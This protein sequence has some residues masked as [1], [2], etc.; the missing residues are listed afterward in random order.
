MMTLLKNILKFILWVLAF[1]VVY[2]LISLVLTS[3]TVNK[4]EVGLNSGKTIYLN[5]NGVHLDIVIPVNEV[6]DALK[7][8]LKMKDE[9]YLSFGWGDE[10]FYLNTPTWNDLT[11]K[12]AFSAMF[13]K[14]N[15]LIHLT[16]H[17]R[18]NPK[19]TVVNLNEKQLSKL[20]TYILKTFQFDNHGN[21]IILENKG[22]AFNDDFYKAKGSYSIVKT[23][24]SWANS[25]LKTSGLKSC[26]WTPFDFG[27][28]NKYKD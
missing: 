11:F 17:S 9:K 4:G 5:T 8:G 27:I 18:K 2:L 23:C 25:A 6:D 12:T 20:N 7:K 22:Y 13:L 26:F 15:A 21:K 10:N 1:P 14:G 24:N 3:I 28:I 19:W 16:R